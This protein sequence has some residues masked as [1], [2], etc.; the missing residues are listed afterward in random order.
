V[1]SG[2]RETLL[3]SCTRVECDSDLSLHRINSS[4][5]QLCMLFAVESPHVQV[6][7]KTPTALLPLL[8]SMEATVYALIFAGL[9][10]CGFHGSAAI[11]E[12]FFP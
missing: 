10:F 12:S 3:G 9:K 8:H 1:T 6:G 11:R 5:L 7:T 4:S 2:G